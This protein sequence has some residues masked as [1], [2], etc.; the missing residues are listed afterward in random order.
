M[1]R[2]GGRLPAMAPGQLTGLP[3]ENAGERP[4]GPGWFVPLGRLHE[5]DEAVRL[6]LDTPI[7]WEGERAGNEPWLARELS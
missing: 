3:D 2:A 7:G 1:L 4:P 6:S 5:F